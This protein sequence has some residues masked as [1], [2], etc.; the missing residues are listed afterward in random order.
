[1]TPEYEQFLKGKL[2]HSK[3]NLARLRKELDAAEDLHQA[4]EENFMKM[5][6]MEQV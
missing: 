4:K 5:L 6:R 2:K 3:K 1:M